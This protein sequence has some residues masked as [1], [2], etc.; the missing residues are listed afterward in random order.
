MML[1]ATG[2]PVRQSHKPIPS[3]Q[4]LSDTDETTNDLWMEIA[5]LLEPLDILALQSTCRALNQALYRK[6]VWAV[7]LRQVCCEHSLF[8]PT[9]P[10]DTMDTRQLFIAAMGPYRFKS[11]IES[12]GSF[13]SHADDAPALN[14]AHGPFTSHQV[15]VLPQRGASYLVPGGR[16]LLTFNCKA[17]TLWDLGLV[18]SAKDI[19]GPQPRGMAHIDFPPGTFV[20]FET[21]YSSMNVSMRQD[22]LRVVVSGGSGRVMLKAFEISHF[23]ETGKSSFRHLGELVLD[24]AANVRQIVIDGDRAIFEST[25][26]VVWDFISGLYIVVKRVYDINFSSLPLELE[27]IYIH[28]ALIQLGENSLKITDVPPDF[29]LT[30]GKPAP[31]GAS[32]SLRTAEQVALPTSHTIQYPPPDD[33]VDETHLL[34]KGVANRHQ[35]RLPLLFDVYRPYRS[36]YTG[37]MRLAFTFAR[38]PLG[39][40]VPSPLMC[41]AKRAFPAGRKFATSDN[42]GSLHVPSGFTKPIMRAVPDSLRES[43]TRKMKYNAVGVY[44][45]I[46][47]TTG[48]REVFNRCSR[49]EC[50]KKEL[51]KGTYKFCSGCRLVCYC[52]AKCQKGHWKSHKEVCK[53]QSRCIASG[54]VAPPMRIVKLIPPIP[55]PFLTTIGI[56]SGSG[57][58]VNSMQ[59][60]SN[61][62]EGGGSEKWDLIGA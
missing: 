46:Y 4:Y 31:T 11:L 19:D 47:S 3:W 10:I 50:R 49:P 41:I 57:R 17:L 28:N 39:E 38:T 36:G 14:P 15:S 26:M 33:I 16:F 21:G 5:A 25:E 6:S 62:S 44:E 60:R 7:A 42:L 58:M 35:A 30:F 9:F 29:V 2:I 53:E 52:S 12:A 48:A 8:L 55:V 40:V 43:G 18:G 51:G 32:V 23:S 20:E 22:S 24:Y 37:I 13:A 34:G 56:C 54:A 59:D 45:F 27:K 61:P 1:D